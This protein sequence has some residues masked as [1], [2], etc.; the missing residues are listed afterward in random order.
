MYE[1]EI[2]YRLK[3]P[4]ALR[5][6]LK[7]LG[8]RKLG[9]DQERNELYDDGGLRLKKAGC[10]LRVRDTGKSTA[11]LTYKGPAS[12]GPIKKRLEIETH[13]DTSAI[14]QILK[15][16]GFKT[17]LR[18]DKVRET[19]QLKKCLVTIDFL[20][21]HGAFSEIEG[22]RAQILQL[23]KALGFTMKDREDRT[24]AQIVKGSA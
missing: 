19:Y 17:Q 9:E 22:P 8:A 5:R 20:K 15:Y 10:A 2:K 13:V 24:Y 21:G 11:V 6:R 3:D 14:R 18:Y 1:I 7:S 16:L 4:V 23:E 12:K